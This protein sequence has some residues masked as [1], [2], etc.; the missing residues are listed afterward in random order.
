M[1]MN[2]SDV[3]TAR[4]LGG[5]TQLPDGSAVQ[6]GRQ[7]RLPGGQRRYRSACWRRSR[8][9]APRTA[10]PATPAAGK[11]YADSFG[12]IS[13]TYDT[14]YL[15]V[16]CATQNYIEAELN[17]NT[18]VAARGD[19]RHRRDWGPWSGRDDATHRCRSATRTR[20]CSSRATTPGSRTWCR[21]TR[22]RSIHRSS[23]TTSTT[24]SATGGTLP[25]GTY[26]Y[27]VTDQF[28][29]SPTRGSVGGCP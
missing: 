13:H 4:H 23:T 18:N 25:A 16:G 11:P 9:P 17:E 24:Q 5:D 29:N 26:E 15:D 22:P 14:P 8:P 20:T 7:R 2:P 3:A 28:T 21:G 19:R 1:R 12:W 6:H 27:A 10:G